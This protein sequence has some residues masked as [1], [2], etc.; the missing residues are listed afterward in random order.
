MRGNYFGQVLLPSQNFA[1]LPQ[2]K[3]NVDFFW[4]IALVLSLKNLLRTQRHEV[5]QLQ[6]SN[7]RLLAKS[8]IKT[9]E[10]TAKKGVK[11]VTLL[12]AIENRRFNK[13]PTPTGRITTFNVLINKPKVF[14]SISPPDR[15]FE[16]IF[17]KN[18][19]SKGVANTA[20]SVDIVVIETDKATLAL[21]MKQTTF[22]AVPPGQL[23]TKIKPIVKSGDRLN[24]LARAQPVRGMIV[25]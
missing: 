18:V 5:L 22:D 21:A 10:R 8:T 23:E 3:W 19:V 25:Y 13:I 20:A 24:S 4:I 17:I 11:G 7:F 6:L 12:T 9:I 15:S 2:L 16:I 14:T 1:F